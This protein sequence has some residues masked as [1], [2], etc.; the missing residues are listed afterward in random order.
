[1]SANFIQ[2]ANQNNMALHEDKFELM[3]HKHCPQSLL[4]VLSFTADVMSYNVS[5]I[6]IQVMCCSQKVKS[7]I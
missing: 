2:W 6:Y 7:K 5:T 4:Y 1:M 3:V